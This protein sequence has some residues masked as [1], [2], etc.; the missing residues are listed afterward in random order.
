[1]K[2][3]TL[4]AVG[5]GCLAAML[6]MAACSSS[7]DGPLPPPPTLS[8]QC[9]SSCQSPRDSDHPCFGQAPVATCQQTCESSLA[10]KSSD[11]AACILQ[12]TGWHGTSCDCANPEHLGDVACSDC[13]YTGAAKGCSVELIDKCTDGKKTC[14]GF[15]SAAIDDPECAARCGVAPD[16]GDRCIAACRPPT[17]KSDPC[18]GATPDQVTACM[19]TC[20]TRLR[21]ASD[22]CATCYM[23]HSPWLATTCSCSGGSC[24]GCNWY[25]NSAGSVKACGPTACSQGNQC[26]GF[27]DIGMNNAT[28]ADLCGVPFDAGPDA[29]D[30]TDATDSSDAADAADA[31][32]DG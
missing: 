4:I 23:Q 18:S 15:V 31:P 30:A 17:D 12:I 24:S 8:E 20:T 27:Q 22:A 28:C 29:T 1:M 14:S 11:C 32:I 9:A 10:D 26:V 25:G 5:S 2:R 6:V 16:A 7:N 3:T 19:T 21:G 13:T